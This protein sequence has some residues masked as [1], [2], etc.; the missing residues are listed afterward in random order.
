[1]TCRERGRQGNTKAKAKTESDVAEPDDALLEEHIENNTDEQEHDKTVL[2]PLKSGD[3]DSDTETVYSYSSLD[4]DVDSG[5]GLYSDELVPRPK[6]SDVSSSLDVD[7]D[8]DSLQ[9]YMARMYRR[10]SCQ[11]TKRHKR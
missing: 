4:V 11:I 9:V 1:M 2:L 8:N 3:D 10:P 5:I 7:G 6:M